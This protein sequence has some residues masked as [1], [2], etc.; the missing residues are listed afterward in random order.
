VSQIVEIRVVA[1]VDRPTVAENERLDLDEMVNAALSARSKHGPQ[2]RIASQ[3]TG[4]AATTRTS[5]SL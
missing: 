2:R 5:G 4:S 3:G 1:A